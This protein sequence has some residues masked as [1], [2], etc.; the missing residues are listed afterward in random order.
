MPQITS[1]LYEKLMGAGV[2]VAS[3]FMKTLHEA[4]ERL[5][6]HELP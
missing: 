5:K 1:V 4:V 3:A 6:L 2:R